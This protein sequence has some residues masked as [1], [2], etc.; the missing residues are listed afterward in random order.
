M[1][2]FSLLLPVCAGEGTEI[3]DLLLLCRVCG[4]RGFYLCVPEEADFQ[5]FLKQIR[6]YAGYD[7]GVEVVETDR[8]VTLSTC[9]S[10]RRDYRYIVHGKL[11]EEIAN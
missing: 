11:T 4:E 8:V 6:S 5:A 3:S 2:G 1:G 7:T 10:S 9:V